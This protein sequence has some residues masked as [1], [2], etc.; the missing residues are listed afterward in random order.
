MR[1]YG[2]KARAGGRAPVRRRQ[3]GIRCRARNGGVQ[4]CAIAIGTLR[5]V[6]V[7]VLGSGDAFGSGGRLHSGYLVETDDHTF[8]LD[9][10]P[11]VLQGLKRARID[12]ARIDFVL[13]THLHGD[14]F[15]GVPFLFLEYVYE[16]PRTRPIEIVGPP[17]TEQRCRTLYEALYQRIAHEPAPYAVSY[18]ELQPTPATVQ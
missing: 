15:G 11:S 14:H 18:R 6:R 12:T 8:L 5:M 13:L 17:A 3:D 16:N 1:P 2:S 9:C 4:A 7:T 10:G